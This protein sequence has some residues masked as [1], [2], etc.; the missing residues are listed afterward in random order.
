[1]LPD[2][3]A[4][5]AER[6]DFLINQSGTDISELLREVVFDKRRHSCYF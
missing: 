3:D 6:I 5:L 4:F 1:M 2:F